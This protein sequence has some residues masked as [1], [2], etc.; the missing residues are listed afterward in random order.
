M[1][2]I[3]TSGFAAGT[4]VHTKEGLMPIEQIKV[5][6]YV[7]SKPESGEGE[8][9]YKRVTQVFAH[10]PERVIE[11]LYFVGDDRNIAH[12]IVTTLNHPF[13]AVGKGWTAAE[14]LKGRWSGD[15]KLELFDGSQATVHRNCKIYVSDKPGVG[16][17]SSTSD[18][19]TS[20]PGDLWDYINHRLV[21][22]NVP[23]LKHF[24]EVIKYEEFE[25]GENANSFYLKLPVYNL[26]VEDFHTYYV[27]KH[28][29]WVNSKIR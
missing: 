14:D 13:W 24:E 15:D 21:A 25:E 18:D 2:K 19:V 10:K 1:P 4:L 28:G 7:L 22:T 8:Q 11:M 23:P 9:A 12:P 26:E 5:G 29:V 20:L 16:W 6:D 17:T 3:S 27:G